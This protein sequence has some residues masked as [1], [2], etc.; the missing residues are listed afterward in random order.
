MGRPRVSENDDKG[1]AMRNLMFLI[2]A[3]A[4]LALSFGAVAC[5]DD[6]EDDGDETTT[7]A[8]EASAET[9]DVTGDDFSF[10]LSATPTA[11]TTEV[12]FE[13]V[14]KEP[15]ELIFAR[16]NEGFTVEDAI[17]AE[18]EE[19][20]AEEIGFTFAKPGEEAKPIEIKKP[21]EPGNYAMVCAIPFKGQP[22]FDLGMQEEFTIE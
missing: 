7:A 12:T 9:V 5:G 2:C 18:G 21:L 16:I 1:I 15:H 22:H 19:G 13:N 20:T 11:E 4:V 6:D 3:L 8:E 14:G 17:K 10:E